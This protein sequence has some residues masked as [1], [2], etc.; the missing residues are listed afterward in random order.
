MVRLQKPGLASA[1][2]VAVLAQGCRTPCR[3]CAAVDPPAPLGTLIDPVWEQQEGNA[4]ASDFV[5]LEHEFT[6]NT[7]RLN[8]AGQD[9]VKKIAV[10]VNQTPF[11]IIVAPSSMTPDSNDPFGFPVHNNPELDL[12][13]R[14]VIVSLLEEMGVTDAGTRVVVAPELCPGY[15]SFEAQRAYYSGFSRLGFGRGG[16]GGGGGGGFGGGFGGGGAF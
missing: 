15:Q 6:G 4:E 7:A 9:H 1:L 8:A 12:Q 3:P 11:P 14:D 13:R 16:G 10:R 5:V 2:V